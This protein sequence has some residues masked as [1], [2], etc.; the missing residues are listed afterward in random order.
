MVRFGAAPSG[1]AAEGGEQIAL[2][3]CSQRIS[4]NLLLICRGLNLSQGQHGWI[5][6]A[7]LD[8]IHGF[9][10]CRPGGWAAGLDAPRLATF[11]IQLSEL[12]GE[13]DFSLQKLQSGRTIFG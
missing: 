6:E 4:K 5:V 12:I 8:D 3:I 10:R 9:E 2:T 7:P 1:V 11:Q 13:R